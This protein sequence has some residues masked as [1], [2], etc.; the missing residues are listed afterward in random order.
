[1]IP[2]PVKILSGAVAIAFF[3]IVLLAGSRRLNKR[4]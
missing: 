4:K 1:M 2:E 3:I